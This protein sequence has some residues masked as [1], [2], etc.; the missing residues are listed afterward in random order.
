[1]TTPFQVVIDA[2]DP[3]MVNR[4]WSAAMGYEMED[5]HDFIKQLLDSGA[6][7]DDDV[8]EID[9]RLAF[10][11][12]AASR[13]PAGVAPRLLFQLVPEPKSVKNRVHLDLH[14]G[15]ERRES[16]VE[17]LIGLGASRLW[18]GQQGPNR[19]VTM[20]DPEGNEFCVA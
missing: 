15:D 2:A 7:T 11:S 1:M 16:E 4:F 20:A 14:V 13:D 6:V 5:H 17:R 9:G 3:H 12:G 19:W 18:D 10:K 8:V